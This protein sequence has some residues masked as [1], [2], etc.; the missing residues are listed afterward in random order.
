M[1]IHLKDLV[2]E[3]KA[4]INEVDCAQA[5]DM[6]QSGYTPLDVRESY[7][8][9]NGTIP[10]SKHISRGLLEPKCDM[11]FA[12]HDPDMEDPDKCWLVFCQAGGRGALATYTMR[13]MGFKNVV[14]LTGG[15][16]AWQDAGLDV[17]CPPTEEGL[18]L[19]NHPWNP[20][21]S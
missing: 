3:A 16:K 15:F 10:M 21:H 17:T 11:D 6:L 13:K 7:E 5:S 18:M 4:I 1:P 19:C 20:Q 9:L 2:T 14:N 12:G 8:Y